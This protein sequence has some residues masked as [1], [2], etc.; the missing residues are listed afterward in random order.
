MKD[1]PVLADRLDHQVFEIGESVGQPLAL[2]DALVKINFA[3]SPVT[4]G[5]EKEVAVTF[6]EQYGAP[7]LAGKD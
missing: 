3:D 4:A 6:P 7:N 1:N 2:A 5:D